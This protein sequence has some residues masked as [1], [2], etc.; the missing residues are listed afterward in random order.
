MDVE[1]LRQ[2]CASRDIDPSGKTRDELRELIKE[3]ESP[4]ARGEEST[5]GLESLRLKLEL[6]R[7]ELD[8]KESQRAYEERE[9]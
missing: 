8:E 2:E 9:K 3:Y 4:K 1:T 5:E 6:K 7:I